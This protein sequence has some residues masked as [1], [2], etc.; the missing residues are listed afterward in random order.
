MTRTADGA[1]ARTTAAPQPGVGLFVRLKLRLIAGALHGHFGRQVGF[2]LGLIFAASIAPTGFI[3]LA[4]LHGRGAM[5][6]DLG[7]MA[8]TVV[9]IAWAMLPLLVFGT[10]ETLD[11]TRLALFPLTRWT[12]ARGLFTT[13]LVG[14]GPLATV[15]VLLGAAVGLSGGPLSVLVGI[16]AV[17]LQ[18]ALCIAASRALAAAFSSLLRSR[19][20]RDLAV[21][22]GLLMIV[23]I[24]GAN[25]IVQRA[26]TSGLHGSLDALREAAGYARWAPPGMAADAIAQARDGR[27]GV[28][29][30]ELAVTAATVAILMWLWVAA[31]GR[32][33]ETYDASTQRGPERRRDRRVRTLRP[34][35]GKIGAV[36]GKELRYAWRDPRRKVGWMAMIGVGIVVTFSFT[37]PHTVNAHGPTLPMYF[38]AAVAGLQAAN[39][40]GVDGPATWLN[41]VTIGRPRDMRADLVGRNLA[42]AVVAIPCLIVLDVA[43]ALITG[44]GPV[45]A[46]RALAF[47]LGV[48]GITL[49]LCD[50]TSVRFPYALPQR[51]HNPF[52]GP[53]SGRGCLA[54]LTSMVTMTIT[55]LLAVPLM[56]AAAVLPTPWLAVTAPAYGL[57][58][59]AVGSMV[60][61]NLG[62]A[63][64]PE[65][66]TEISRG[67]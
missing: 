38:A 54:G 28:A 17:A 29:L 55:G 61:A 25:L 24:Q 27:Y 48:Y 1:P 14:V 22:F 11:P 15:I 51:A 16:V 26:I 47:A 43:I 46:L 13:A 36:V 41:A 37:N 21:V 53:G 40:Y 33:L 62:F 66:L 65:L 32:M 50:I 64:L 2:V 3:G 44:A 56:I 63:R 59:V 35:A 45:D 31:L 58:G 8:F 49:G 67:M 42:H 19:R 57:L 52:A 30:A 6:T 34:V 18:V 7:V 23:I 60:A 39:Q 12:L 20:G 5:A 4:M 10:D 9:T